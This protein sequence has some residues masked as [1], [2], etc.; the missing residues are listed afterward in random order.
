MPIWKE[1]H[2]AK[3]INDA[4]QVLAG[5]DGQ[6]KIVAGGT[7]LILDLQQGRRP[8]VQILLDVMGISELKAVEVRGDDLFIGAAVPLNSIVNSQ[9][10][11]H[12]VQALY[13]ACSLIGG[14][15]VRNVATLGGNVVHGLPAGD[16]TISL[17]SLNAK[18]EIVSLKGT[19]VADLQKLYSGP[20]ETARA[21]SMNIGRPRHNRWV[22]AG[23]CISHFP[24]L[25]RLLR[26]KL[27]H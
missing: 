7:D 23:I 3:S 4:L 13:E 6:A 8:P 12:N 5:A 10:V 21:R 25:P 16:G 15:Q 9:L 1:Y 27:I 19:R 2:I 17:L 11:F 22:K 18:A 14:P 20:G 26:L 24:L